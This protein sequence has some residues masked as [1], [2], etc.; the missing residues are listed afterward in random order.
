MTSAWPTGRICILCTFI[1]SFITRHARHSHENVGNFC[2]ISSL[3]HDWLSRLEHTLFMWA[4]NVLVSFTDWEDLLCICWFFF[5]YH[6]RLLM[7]FRQ[8][9]VVGAADFIQCEQVFGS[10]TWCILH[11]FVHS[12]TPTP[13]T[14]LNIAILSRFPP[15]P[16]PS[17]RKPRDS[18]WTVAFHCFP[19][20]CILSPGTGV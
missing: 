6:T 9:F 12:T 16:P 15:F 10:I 3:F 18:D 19:P 1:E 13:R 8:M 5:I 14:L 20:S 17:V 7:Y 11:T 2:V 4:C